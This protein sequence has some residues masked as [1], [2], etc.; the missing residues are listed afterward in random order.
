MCTCV[1]VCVCVCKSVC[2]C[3]CDENISAFILTSTVPLIYTISADVDE[4]AASV[5][6]GQILR[7]HGRSAQVQA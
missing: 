1:C 6:G 3:A 4:C 7:Q 2:V 5:R